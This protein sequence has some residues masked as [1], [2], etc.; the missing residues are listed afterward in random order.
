MNPYNPYAAPAAPAAA[1]MIIGRGEPQPWDVGSAL[2]QAW[3]LYKPNWAALTFG[4]VL[5]A[6]ISALPGQLVGVLQLAGLVE[7][8]TAGYYAAQG[9]VA[10]IGW[11]IG[12]FFAVGFTRVAL[13]TTRTGTASFGDF[14]SGASRFLPFVGMSL[15]RAIAVVGG[16]LLLVVP[17]VILALGFSNAPFYCVDQQLG[18]VASLKTSW[19]STDGHK[20][21]LFVYTLAEV[22]LLLG[23]LLACCLGVLVVVPVTMVGRALIYTLMSGTAAPPVA[24]PGAYDAPPG[25]YLGPAGYG[26][27]SP[28]YGGGPG[29]G[30]PPGY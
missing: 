14:F 18:P 9:G 17:G 7:P 25:G 20:S 6:F 8:G 30:G 24:P 5:I 16:T 23:G 2:R 19:E 10:F 4:Y 12:E 1:P 27:P 11:I 13:Q 26:P 22:G 21:N 28:G 3:E 29:Y 15:L